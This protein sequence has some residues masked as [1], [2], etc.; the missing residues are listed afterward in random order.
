MGALDGVNVVEAGLLVQ[1]P[2]A[3][4]TLAAWGATVVKVELPGFGDQ[5]RWLPV[6]PGDRRAPFFLACNRGKRSLALDLRRP[7]GQAVFRRLAAWADVVIS[8]FTPGTMDSWGLGYQ[9]LAEVNPRLVVASGSCFGSNGP[10]AA[11][12]GADLSGQAASG[13]AWSAGGAAGGPVALAAT[14]ADHV[15]AQ[16]L[17]GGILAA[18][19]ARERTGR[20]QHIETSLLGGQLWAQA[21]EVTAHLL[22]G[23]LP[24]RSLRDHPLVPGIYG[25]FE[26]ADGWIAVVGVAGPDRER[27]FD[28][29]GRPDLGAA[30]PQPLY[31]PEER[32]A[33]FPLLDEV[34]KTR[35]TAAWVE[36]FAAAGIRYAEVRHLDEVVCDPG[37]WANGYLAAAPGAATD[38]Q[39]RP[40]PQETVVCPP[41]RFSATPTR[42]GN[43]APELGAHSFEI[44]AELGYDDEEI[45]A[46]A[47]DDVI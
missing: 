39:G 10:D 28:L 40:A 20:G 27:F 6:G 33:L 23:R 37:V 31:F 38:D 5:S 29:I 47:A 3:A 32:A 34:F 36:L 24:D 9:A 11:R 15:A 26:T 44:L 21:A 45:A 1:G 2:Q 22:T 17:V 12:S 14:I 42:V 46:L 30:F 43:P 35:P 7:E 8:N 41:V 18:L 25:M 16:N 4:A 13:L 19:Y